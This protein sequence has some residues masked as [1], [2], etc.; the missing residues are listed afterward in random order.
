MLDWRAACWHALQRRRVSSVV[1]NAV[2]EIGGR[3]MMGESIKANGKFLRGVL[4]FGLQPLSQQAVKSKAEE[5][6]AERIS[7][8]PGG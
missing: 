8:F 1:Y 7:D 6:T 3:W 5:W 4:T 2:T